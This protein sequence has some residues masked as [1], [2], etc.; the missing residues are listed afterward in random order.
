MMLAEILN[1]VDFTNY[2]ESNILGQGCIYVL[3]NDSQQDSPAIVDKE[4]NPITE[5]KKNRIGFY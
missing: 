4:G 5:Q 3:T 2:T 1:E